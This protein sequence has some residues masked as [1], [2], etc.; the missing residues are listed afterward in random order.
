MRFFLLFFFSV[1]TLWPSSADYLRKIHA[2][3]MIE[4]CKAATIV[5]KEA[6]D[7][8]PENKEIHETYIICLAKSH[9]IDDAIASYALLEEES[10][11]V[12]EEI[13]W[14]ILEKG[15]TSSQYAIRLQALHAA[16][17]AQDRRSV[18]SLLH[19]MEDENA[20][21]RSIAIQLA[22]RYR[23]ESLKRA[24]QGLL[25]QEQ[26]WLVRSELIQAAGKMQL[27]RVSPYLENLL[28]SERATFEEKEL[29][30]RALVSMY[31]D[32]DG[33]KIARFANSPKAL[34]RQLACKV[35]QRLEKEEVRDAILPLLT[36]ERSEVRIAALQALTWVFAKAMSNEERSCA[37]AKPL[38]DLDP[39]VAIT[40]AWAATLMGQKKGLE[41]LEEALISSSQNKRRLASGAIAALGD[42]ASTL[43]EKYLASSFDPYVRVHLALALLGQRRASLQVRDTLYEFLMEKTTLL[44]YGPYKGT[45]FT[46]FQPSDVPYV[47]QIPNYPLVID[48]C[49]QLQLLSFLA[50]LQDSRA[51]FAMQKFLCKS[52]WGISAMASSL[53]LQEGNEESLDLIRMLLDQDNVTVRLQAAIVLAYLGKEQQGIDV[54]QSSYQD[55]NR[56]NKQK[57]L[58]ALSQIATRKDASFFLHALEEPLESLR[59]LAASGLIQCLKR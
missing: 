1:H 29:A 23:D 28:D 43:A 47:P 35:A 36:D 48:E 45:P 57:I 42:R 54:L 8:F 15:Q 11:P 31:E 58:E 53:L 17:F 6:F 52:S 51:P 40:A 49:A 55:A 19:T 30:M 9:A 5:A 56:H 34:I 10:P 38:Q 37:L 46:L 26:N 7:L 4:D 50:I 25:Y 18:K 41:R 3:W 27:K 14:G 2:H 33:E 12:L 24:V 16:Y 22:S 21:L 32:M 13:A 39:A 44:Q 59:I 20:I